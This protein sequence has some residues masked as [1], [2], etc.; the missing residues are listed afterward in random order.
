[1]LGEDNYNALD[2]RSDGEKISAHA[3]EGGKMRHVMQKFESHKKAFHG[4]SP[5]MILELPHPLHTVDIPGKVEEG[6]LTITK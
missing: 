3:T 2:C 5:K 6:D 4:A 1:V